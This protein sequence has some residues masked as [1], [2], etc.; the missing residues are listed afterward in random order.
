[1]SRLRRPLPYWAVKR[2]AERDAEWNERQRRRMPLV[3]LGTQDPNAVAE[4]SKG[5]VRV[6]YHDGVFLCLDCESAASANAIAM[7]AEGTDLCASCGRPVKDAIH[8]T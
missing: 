5:L 8:G 1:M 7:Q 4:W 2:N 3:G 6:L